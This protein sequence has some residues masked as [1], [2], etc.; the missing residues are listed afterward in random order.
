[1][2][3]EGDLIRGKA[4][5]RKLDEW[6]KYVTPENAVEHFNRMLANQDNEQSS[7]LKAKMIAQR[8]NFSEEFILE[9]IKPFYKE[10]GAFDQLRGDTFWGDGSQFRPGDN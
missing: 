7:L 3:T 4:L 1:M 5:N 9:S 6:L 10:G 2:A 8:H